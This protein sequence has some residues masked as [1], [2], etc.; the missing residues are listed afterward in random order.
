[1]STESYKTLIELQSDL[2]NFESSV[3]NHFLKIRSL[4]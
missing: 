4:R 3:D 2:K 1:M